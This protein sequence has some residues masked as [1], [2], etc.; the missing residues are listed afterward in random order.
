ML[1]DVLNQLRR[2]GYLTVAREDEGPQIAEEH[3]QIVSAIRNKD[4]QGAKRS[5]RRHIQS[6]KQ[7]ILNVY[8]K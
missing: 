1:A 8:L 7:N 3:A 4:R 5:I 6:A 2:L